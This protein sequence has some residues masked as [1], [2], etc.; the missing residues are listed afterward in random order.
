LVLT[1]RARKGKLPGSML[2][3]PNAGKSTVSAF[4]VARIRTR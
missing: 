4:V 3:N 2:R 1:G